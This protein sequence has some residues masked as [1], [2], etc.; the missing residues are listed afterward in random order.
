MFSTVLFIR[1]EIWKQRECP[2]RVQ[3]FSELWYT[4]QQQVYQTAV[5]YYT[6]TEMNKL[7]ICETTTR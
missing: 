1:T 5:E 2:S 7:Q 4:I 3:S 6:V